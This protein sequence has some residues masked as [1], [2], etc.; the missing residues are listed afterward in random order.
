MRRLKLA[1]VRVLPFVLLLFFSFGAEKSPFLVLEDE[2]QIKL[3]T[4]RLEAVIRKKG[5]VSGVAGG[6]FLDKKTGFRDAGHGLSI[7]DFILEPGS[8]EAYRDQ[9]EPQM[10]YQFGNPAYSPVHGRTAKHYIEGPQICTKAKVLEP[11]VIRGRDF[12]A[13]VMSHQFPWAAPGRK[14]GSVWTQTMVFPA[15]KRYYLCSQ[16]IDSVN[17]SPSMFFRI[18]M[19]G[20]IKHKRGDTF[21]EVYLSYLK[22][23]NG[24]SGVNG[25]I[26]PASAFFNDFSPDEK[27]N[28]RRDRAKSLPDRIIRAYRL[29]DPNTGA[30][31]PWLAGMTLDPSDVY[32]LWCHQRG[33]VCMIEEFGGRA[34]RAGESFSAAFVVGYFDSVE[35]MESL[36][37]QYRDHSGLSVNE[38]GWKLTE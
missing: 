7:A 9:I 6:T 2:G 23:T 10:V 14:T 19:P 12:V 25:E 11:R 26:L 1:A 8:D 28:Y 31:G 32:E 33:Y 17:S 27:F 24:P 3:I 37:D 21:S 5:Y 36:Y 29:L 15:G 30:S 22:W 35:E 18:D 4:D 20:H 34:I 13:V 16:R 38:D